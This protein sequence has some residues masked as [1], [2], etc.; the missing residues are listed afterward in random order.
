[1]EE[2]IFIKPSINIAEQLK[3]YYEELNE[4][5]KKEETKEEKAIN[6]NQKFVDLSELLTEDIKLKEE[7][8]ETIEYFYLRVRDNKIMGSVQLRQG[9]NLNCGNISYTIRPSERGKGYGKR[10]LQDFKVLAKSEGFD[11]LLITCFVDNL[12][13]KKI[14]LANG[15]IYDSLI[16]NKEIGNVIERYWLELKNI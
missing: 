14:I 3:S 7:F 16:Y 13:S 5:N 1:M 12:P 10:M 9:E 6:K 8:F 2:L 11:K 4:L 15:G